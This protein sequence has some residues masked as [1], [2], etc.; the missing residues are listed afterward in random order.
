VT[1]LLEDKQPGS[2]AGRRKAMHPEHELIN[3]H[4]FVLFK[5]LMTMA[6]NPIVFFDR[7]TC[8]Y[9]VSQEEC[10]ILREGVP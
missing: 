6:V 2:E 10:A 7:T 8:V 5:I 3:I 9:R 4:F 1:K